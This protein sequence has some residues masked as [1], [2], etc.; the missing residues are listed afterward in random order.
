MTELVTIKTEGEILSEREKGIL[1]ATE[2]LRQIKDLTDEEFLELEF[3]FKD[4]LQEERERRFG[5]YERPVPNLS[6]N[7]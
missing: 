3:L 1:E 5:K 4:Y 6:N 7:Y 2:T